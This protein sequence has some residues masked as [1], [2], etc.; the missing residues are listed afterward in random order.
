MEFRFLFI[1]TVPPKKV[2]CFVIQNELSQEEGLTPRFVR[3]KHPAVQAFR[4]RRASSMCG[5]PTVR[6]T[7]SLRSSGR[8]GLTLVTQI[9]HK[10][11]MRNPQIVIYAVH[12]TP[13]IPFKVE[14]PAENPFR[15]CAHIQDISYEVH[16]STAKTLAFCGNSH[17]SSRIERA[18]GLPF[19]RREA[20]AYLRIEHAVACT[21]GN[22]LLRLCDRGYVET[23]RFS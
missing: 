23:F 12:A 7:S 13:L 2:I 22:K 4:A 14:T 21:S 9:L 17:V 1:S 20:I 15:R 6:S 8:F 11:Q 19:F 5:F 10:E 18:P 3:R 16:R